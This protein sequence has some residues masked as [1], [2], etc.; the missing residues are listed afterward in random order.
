MNRQANDMYVTIDLV[1][2]A[3]E[4]QLKKYKNKIMDKHQPA[5]F[6]AGFYREDYPEEEEVQICQ[7]PRS[8]DIAD[9]SRREHASRWSRWD[10]T[11]VFLLQC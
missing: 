4:R 11:F 6:P 3:I 2:E 7:N 1:E 9:V 8:L 10:I 5:R